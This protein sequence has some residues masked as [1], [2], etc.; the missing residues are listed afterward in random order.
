[1]RKREEDQLSSASRTVDFLA[2]NA[3]DLAVSEE[4]AEKSAEVQVLYTKI[5]GARAG[6]V[7]TTKRLTKEAKTARTTVLD[8]LPGLLGPMA[9]VA[10]ALK[11]QDLLASVTLSTKQLGRLR[12]LAFIG[13]VGSV[14]GSA[15]RAD[16]VPGL[17]KH[18]L[19]PKTLAPLIK[20]HEEFVKA[21]PAPRKTI[22]E[23][24]LA[25]AALSDLLGDLMD[26]LRDLDQAMK[27]FKLI[28]RPLYDGYVQMRKIINT[29]GG[30]AEASEEAPAA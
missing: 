27:A 2:E 12:P 11:D 29:G 21:Q 8:L 23:R 22:D 20:A 14:L 24:L 6:V 16:V 26:E 9:R 17:V 19:T 18:G 10:T 3:A 15:E 30:K 25:G 1:M 7:K 4:V 28:D 13:V 5:S